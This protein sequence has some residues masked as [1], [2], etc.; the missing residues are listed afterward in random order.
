MSCEKNTSAKPSILCIKQEHLI[1]YKK[2]R[3]FYKKYYRYEREWAIRGYGGKCAC[4]GF[5]D[6]D[7]KI[8][9]KSFLNIDHVNGK[10]SQHRRETGFDN[11]RFVLRNKWPDSHRVLCVSCNAAME[12]GERICELHKWEK[13]KI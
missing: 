7:K 2:A 1:Q 4:C 11:Y 3:E 13:N 10:G 8:F 9:N 5:D 12:P 6:V